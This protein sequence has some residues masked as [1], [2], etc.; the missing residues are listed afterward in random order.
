MRGPQDVL[1]MVANLCIV[2]LFFL[3]SASS[4]TCFETDNDGLTHAVT[5]DAWT[6]CALTPSRT[7]NGEMVP[8]RAFGVGPVTDATEQY[9]GAFAISEDFYSVL[10]VCV[11]EKYDFGKVS[12]K[13]MH[14][15][16]TEY[17]FRCVCHYDLCNRETT[18]S[19]Y[20][21]SMRERENAKQ[22]H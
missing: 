10:T 19:A 22:V 15:N 1:N 4:L 11:Y 8:G 13:H 9:D 14:T 16:W 12:P 7:H 18:F 2:L 3:S 5:N 20:L 17:L 21:A 6:Y